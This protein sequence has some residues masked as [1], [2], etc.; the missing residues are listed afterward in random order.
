MHKKELFS[1]FLGAAKFLFQSGKSVD[2]KKGDLIGT[3]GNTG[4]SFGDHL[5]FGVYR[6]SAIDQLSNGDWY[7]NNWV[8]PSQILSPKTVLWD[9]G[10]EP[11][12]TKNYR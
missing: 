4:Y 3:Q 7:H 12:E 8:D 10:C 11:K 5:H 6:Y 2:V 1:K 9:T